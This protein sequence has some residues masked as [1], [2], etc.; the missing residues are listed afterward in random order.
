MCDDGDGGTPSASM[1]AIDGSIDAA[2]AA[3][4]TGALMRCGFSRRHAAHR[5]TPKHAGQMKR[6]DASGRGHVV[7]T[8]SMQLRQNFLRHA[9]LGYGTWRVMRCVHLNIWSTCFFVL[10]WWHERSTAGL[11][12]ESSAPRTPKRPN[13]TVKRKQVVPGK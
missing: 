4:M 2:A 12:E 8:L 10:Q 9:L 13:A 11:A 3:V 5:H 1:D 7:Y 6:D